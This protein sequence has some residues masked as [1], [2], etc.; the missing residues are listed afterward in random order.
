MCIQFMKKSVYMKKA[1]VP[2]SIDKEIH[3]R[4]KH[5]IKTHP[6][7]EYKI[8]SKFVNEALEEKLN[9]IEDRITLESIRKTGLDEFVNKAKMVRR[10]M[11]GLVKFY[12]DYSEPVDR[13]WVRA[14]IKKFKQ[15][16]E[17]K[18]LDEKE[19]RKHTHHVYTPKKK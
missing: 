6:E 3:L 14:E 11:P 18:Q 1:R 2:A 8:I 19:K 15:S 12:E 7:L 16:K 9:K 10:R 4:I 13:E 17:F 5:L